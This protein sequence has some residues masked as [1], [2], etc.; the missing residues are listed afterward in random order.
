MKSKNPAHLCHIYR[1]KNDAPYRKINMRRIFLNLLTS[2]Q[3]LI[4][5]G[6][7]ALEHSYPPYCSVNEP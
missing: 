4:D 7:G 1:G 5:Q 6:Y 2:Q 3:V